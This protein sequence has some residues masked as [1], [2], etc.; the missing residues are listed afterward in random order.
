[1][2]QIGRLTRT[3]ETRKEA[4]IRDDNDKAT[5]RQDSL[6]TYLNCPGDPYKRHRVKGP[7]PDR[8]AMD[9]SILELAAD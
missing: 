1:M 9:R 4:S 2:Q 8:V 6:L 3:D 5:D 7:A